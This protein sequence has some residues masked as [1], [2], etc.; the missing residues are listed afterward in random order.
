MYKKNSSMIYLLILGGVISILM[1]SCKK[2][3]VPLLTTTEVK[4]FVPNL[5]K[6]GGNITND[7]GES[8]IALG[9]C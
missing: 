3:Q 9:V 2:G 6:S 8:I 4:S 1:N 5:A 7:G